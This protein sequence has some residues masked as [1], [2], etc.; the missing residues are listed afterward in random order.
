[1]RRRGVYSTLPPPDAYMGVG[2][3]PCN[4][5]IAGLTAWTPL[6]LLLGV[7]AAA[8]L[9]TGAVA[10]VCLAGCRVVYVGGSERWPQ[11]EPDLQGH[12]V[13]LLLPQVSVRVHAG[14][15]RGRGIW[16]EGRAP[17]ALGGLPPG[18]LW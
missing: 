6:P 16:V 3:S 4:S 18:R 5:P 10:A 17:Q 13:G 15:E 12:H 7:P 2:V 14:R 8:M 1:M 11:L 9:A